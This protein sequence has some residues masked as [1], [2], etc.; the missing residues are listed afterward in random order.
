MPV[1]KENS[2]LP[3][4]IDPFVALTDLAVK[5]RPWW[6]LDE[7]PFTR[8]GKDILLEFAL[9]IDTQNGCPS[10]HIAITSV[11]HP[12]GCHSDSTLNS[13]NHP[14]V[15]YVSVIV[16]DKQI[17][18]KAQQTTSIDDYKLRCDDFEEALLA[19]E[20]VYRKLA[21]GQQ[22]VT[23]ALFKGELA[24]FVPGFKRI[25]KECNMDPMLYSMMTAIN[26]TIRLAKHHI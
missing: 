1:L 26:C 13:K 18:C 2:E 14:G 6:R 23:S 25:T 5:T 15:L 19:I 10:L 20:Q 16:R 22:S 3:E 21:Q 8:I 11:L 24:K 12:C 7:D 9:K 17:S 4:I